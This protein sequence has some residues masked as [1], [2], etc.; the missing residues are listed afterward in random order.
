[1]IVNLFTKKNN[2]SA[3]SDDNSKKNNITILYDKYDKQI[4]LLTEKMK[5]KISVKSFDA[6]VMVGKEKMREMGF[7]TANIEISLNGLRDGFYCV[8]VAF[9][10]QVF[11]GLALTSQEN[12]LA[13]IY[14]IDFDRNI[15]GKKINVKFL[16]F[17]A[18]LKNFDECEPKK[19][20][21]QNLEKAK[22]IFKNN[23]G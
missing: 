7:P 1:M 3:S 10:G 23:K 8:E 4:K 16:N 20:F 22:N 2:A 9:D 17:I 11:D 21:E 19:Q 15:Y 12:K 5:K 18:F 13:E 14:I 6:I